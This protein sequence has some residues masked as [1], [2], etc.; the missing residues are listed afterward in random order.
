[1]N[2]NISYSR[3]IDN[4]AN[5]CGLTS[6]ALDVNVK[7]NTFERLISLTGQNQTA[8]VNQ[9]V[10]ADGSSQAYTGF[11]SPLGV[12]G[13]RVFYAY[14]SA[15]SGTKTINY[16]Y[17]DSSGDLQ[18]VS[19]LS[20]TFNTYTALAGGA[21]IAMVNS[22][23]LPVGVTLGA[24]EQIHISYTASAVG[25]FGY[26][27]NSGVSQQALYCVPNGKKCRVT[28]A[29]LNSAANANWLLFKWNANGYITTSWNWFS[30]TNV[31]HAAGF[32]GALA[33]YSAGEVIAMGVSNNV[34][35]KHFNLS[36]V[37]TADL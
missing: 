9:L 2:S 17:V 6:N 7:S 1:M 15:A 26:L 12:L 33:S 18:S 4:G 36:V 27:N 24:S 5:V 20:L 25:R 19:G 3:I 34:A 28:Q 21:S 23:E 37:E 35:N 29:G 31:I 16:T 22:F 13:P 8:A 10:G 11:A 14:F 30:I 32:N